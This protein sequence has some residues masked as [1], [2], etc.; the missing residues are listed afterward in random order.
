M[1]TSVARELIKNQ[2]MVIC[3][4][5][6]VW[7]KSNIGFWVNFQF[8]NHHPRYNISTLSLLKLYGLFNHTTKSEIIG[9]ILSQGNKA[10]R[11]QG[12]KATEQQDNWATAVTRQCRQQGTRT[13]RQ[14]E[15]QGNMCI[16][17]ALQQDN[18]GNRLMTWIAF[19]S[20]LYGTY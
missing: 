18:M 17:T 9:S 10:T 20:F 14:C 5:G 12:N 4:Y 7:Q 11:K 8:Q 15:Q 2:T 6:I 1:V 13:T 19:Q 16:K 3:D